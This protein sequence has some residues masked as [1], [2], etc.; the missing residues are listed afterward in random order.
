MNFFH[1]FGGKKHFLRIAQGAK[2][3]EGGQLPGPK[4]IFWNH[5][6]LDGFVVGHFFS[7]KEAE[8]TPTKKGTMNYILHFVFVE[9]YGCV[10]GSLTFDVSER[11]ESCLWPRAFFS[12]W[13]PQTGE[14]KTQEEEGHA[15]GDHQT[16]QCWGKPNVF[17][18]RLSERGTVFS[19]QKALSFRFG[20]NYLN[21]ENGWMLQYMKE[22]CDL[23]RSVFLSLEVKATSGTKLWKL[24][25][26]VGARWAFRHLTF[27]DSPLPSTISCW[28]F[29]RRHG[30]HAPRTESEDLRRWWPYCWSRADHH[31]KRIEGKAFW[32]EALWRSHWAQNPKS[33]G[34]GRRIVSRWWSDSGFCRAVACRIGSDC[35]LLQK[36]SW[37]RNKRGHPCRGLPSS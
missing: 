28:R 4:A 37:S 21:I 34:P 27:W 11:S 15:K 6:W 23:Q 7:L 14:T 29:S 36:W 30:C 25:V 18:Y 16:W 5:F 1:H 33:K 22:S 19:P 13:R 2:P 17:L 12:S 9:L 32:K 31:H 26:L 3:G 8:R 20:S 35:H 10:G 24:C